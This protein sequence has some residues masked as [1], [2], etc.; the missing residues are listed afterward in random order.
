MKWH[1]DYYLCKNNQPFEGCIHIK[2]HFRF[3]LDLKIKYLDSLFT[4]ENI[5]LSIELDHNI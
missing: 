3:L 4:P 5:T 1:N 2:E